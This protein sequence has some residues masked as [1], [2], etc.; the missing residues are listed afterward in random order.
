MGFRVY[1]LKEVSFST[2]EIMTLTPS[3]RFRPDEE[4]G[5]VEVGAHP[6]D[7]RVPPCKSMI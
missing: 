3:R 2:S 5:V 4:D 7:K 6:P 1:L